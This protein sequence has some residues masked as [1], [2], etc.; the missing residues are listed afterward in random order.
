M[1]EMFIS[2]E[3]LEEMECDYEVEDNGMSGRYI[4]YHWFTAKK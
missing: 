4:G 3:E 2:F 1:K